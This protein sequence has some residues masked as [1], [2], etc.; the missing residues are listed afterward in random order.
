MAISVP[1]MRNV[2]DISRTENQNTY[3]MFNDVFMKIV[4]FMRECG[5]VWYSRTGNR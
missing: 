2:S 1:R 4:P 5:K 3:F